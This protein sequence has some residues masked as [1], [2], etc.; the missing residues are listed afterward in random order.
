MPNSPRQQRL[1]S[2]FR[3]V[4]KEALDPII[5]PEALDFVASKLA[6]DLWRLTRGAK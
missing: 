4:L 6:L 2:Q 3:D 1:V 5:E